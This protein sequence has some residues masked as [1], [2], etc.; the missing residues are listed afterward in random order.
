MY[1]IGSRCSGIA[2]DPHVSVEITGLRE[3]QETDLALVG[4]LPGMD[5]Q[6]FRQR[7]TVGE[8]LL[9]HPAA[10]R[11]FPGVGPHVRRHRRAL[12]EPPVADCAAERLLPAV[13]PDVGRQVGRLREGLVAGPADVRL[14]PGVR[15][16]VRLQGTRTGVRL[17]ADPTEIRL[18]A[19]L[20]DRSPVVRGRGETTTDSRGQVVCRQLGQVLVVAE[21]VES[22]EGG[23]V[24]DHEDLV[25]TGRPDRMVVMVV[26]VALG[27]VGR[28]VGRGVAVEVVPGG[29]VRRRRCQVVRERLGSGGGGG[30]AEVDVPLVGEVCTSLATAA[31][32]P[33]EWR[34]SVPP[35]GVGVGYSDVHAHRNVDA[36][37]RE[38]GVL[39]VEGR[40]GVVRRMP[41]RGLVVVMRDAVL[42]LEGRRRTGVVA[43]AS[44][45][46]VVVGPGDGGDRSVGGRVA[47]GRGQGNVGLVGQRVGK[48]GGE[49]ARHVPVGRGL[50]DDGVLQGHQGVGDRAVRRAPGFTKHVHVTEIHVIDYVSVT[51]LLAIDHVTVPSLHVIDYVIVSASHA[52]CD[53]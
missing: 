13:R 51:A 35:D 46:S 15:P 48:V 53:I 34:R 7:R 17:T 6:M 1:C 38:E 16:Q 49:A 3:P 24:V 43:M 37:R 22:F 27:V 44:L 11:S 33:A 23:R 36:H 12:R 41:S 32:A 50:V 21:G 29:V 2:V 18:F 4:L 40:R 10:V 19:G 52:N 14:V 31:A 20:Q 28:R 45:A 26:V 8:G 9:A 25:G 30:I 5:A 47:D 42:R 39:A